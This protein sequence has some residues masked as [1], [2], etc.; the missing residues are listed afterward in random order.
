MNLEIQGTLLS[1][2]IAIPLAVIF[3]F[4]L[5]NLREVGRLS[6]LGSLLGSIGSDSQPDRILERLGNS[7][8]KDTAEQYRKTIRIHMPEGDRTN[9]PAASYFSTDAVTWSAGINLRALN[10]AAGQLVGM[11]LLGTFLGLT[12]GLLGFDTEALKESL[13]PLMKGM[14]AS[15]LTSLA[16]ML[17]SI[18]L[19]WRY[20]RSL[21]RFRGQL[22]SLTDALD[23]AYYAD[24]ASVFAKSL[25]D[26]FQ[27]VRDP[28]G[29]LVHDVVDDLRQ[30]MENMV[31][32]FREELSGSAKAEFETLT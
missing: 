25:S 4:F 6:K 30:T 18:F 10:S 20:K 19:N 15:F 7:S 17:S 24:D 5:W 9:L 27:H 28:L 12:V 22:L 14:Y 21:N 29:T 1:L 8:L 26:E 13:R 11:G 31:N 2:S 16:G 3:V 23:G 32:N